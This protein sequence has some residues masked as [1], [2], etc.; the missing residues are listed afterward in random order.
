MK[1]T[2]KTQQR[3]RTRSTSLRQVFRSDL[4]RDFDAHLAQLCVLYEDLRIEVSGASSRSLPRLDVLDSSADHAAT[5]QK[6]G[7]Y[8]RLYFVRRSIA[9]IREFA[10]CLH[11]LRK[12]PEFA[13]LRGS[14]GHTG[15]IFDAALRFFSTN[16]A[17]FRTSRNNIGGH[18]GME[19]AKCAVGK[20]DSKTVGRIEFVMDE[21]QRTANMRLHFVHEITSIAMTKGMRGKTPQEKIEILFERV[22]EAYRHATRV[23]Q[24]MVNVDLWQRFG[25]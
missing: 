21:R 2:R 11:Y 7:G 6:I 12:C 16:E 13:R 23:V 14:A 5:P 17:V 8:R 22:S 20:L 25:K 1:G 15:E 9:T 10:D 19:S 4:S 24:A 3:T 18:F